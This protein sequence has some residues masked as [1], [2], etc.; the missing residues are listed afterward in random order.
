MLQLH[1]H[2]LLFVNEFFR[3][4]QQ[5]KR[6]H[7]CCIQRRNHLRNLHSIKPVLGI[8]RVVQLIFIE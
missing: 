6:H 5:R 4:Q 7:A 1:A 3:E 8:R 2:L